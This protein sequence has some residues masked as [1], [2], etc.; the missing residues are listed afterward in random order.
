MPYEGYKN[1]SSLHIEST[2]AF[3]Y[4][5]PS[6]TMPVTKYRCQPGAPALRSLHLILITAI[7]TFSISIFAFKILHNIPYTP[8]YFTNKCC[9]PP[10]A[11]YLSLI[12]RWW[13][14]FG[15]IGRRFLQFGAPFLFTYRPYIQF[16]LR[17]RFYL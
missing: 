14:I 8:P 9:I 5:T 7:P 13:Q 15:F 10:F 17:L 4:S 6:K 3:P 11:S 16:C 1:S 2:Y 12:H